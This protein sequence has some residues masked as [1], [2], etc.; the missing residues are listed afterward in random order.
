MLAEWVVRF[1]SALPTAGPIAVAG[2][3]IGGAVGQYLLVHGLLDVPRLP[4]VNSVLYDSWPAPHVAR[5]RDPDVAVDDLLGARRWATRSAPAGA[6][7]EELVAEYLDPWT[8][9]RVRRS[10]LAMAAAADS[11]HPL[12]PVPGLRRTAA[13][14]LLVWGEDDRFERVG[15]AE[16]FAAEIPH[17]T[18]VRIPRADRIPTEYAAD[19]I[20]QALGTFF[21]T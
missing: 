13:P 17:S 4:L 2:H 3:D 12:D 7:T 11:R 18:L 16:R 10:W 5:Y 14:K 8:D 21:T 1:A 19:R 20:G 6:A 9:P 15:H